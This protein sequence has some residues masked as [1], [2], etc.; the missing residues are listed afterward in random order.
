M[1]PDA[2]PFYMV[3]MELLTDQLFALGRRLHLPL[4]NVDMGYLVHCQLTALFGTE[5]PQ[6]FVVEKDTG[7]CLSVLG[8]ANLGATDLRAKVQAAADADRLSACNW[9]TLA[10]KRMPARFA[11]GSAFSF[12]TRVCPVVRMSSA[13]PKH[14]KGAEVDSFLARCWAAGDRNVPVSR[15]QVY[16]EWLEGRL[17]TGGGARIIGA[18]VRRFQRERVVRQTQGG[19]REATVCERPDVTLCGTL[20][21]TDS[22][23]FRDLLRKGI[24]RHRSFGFGMLLVR[25]S[26]A[27]TC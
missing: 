24:G 1:S 8:Y 6:P 3:R 16:R 26:G 25:R 12:E 14:R 11:A 2:V 13:G 10:A 19:N 7:R 9:A 4:R 20:E 17:K 15:E 27:N 21:V 18:S 5:A 23:V 22:E